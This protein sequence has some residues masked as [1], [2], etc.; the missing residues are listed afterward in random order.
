[1]R[2]MELT[3]D[4]FG[5]MNCRLCNDVVSVGAI[6]SKCYE[7]PRSVYLKGLEQHRSWPIW[8]HCLCSHMEG[9]RRLAKTL[10]QDNGCC[11]RQSNRACSEC[12]FWGL[13][14]LPACS[15]W[16]FRRVHL[17]ISGLQGKPG[18]WEHGTVSPI[19][20][21]F[22][23]LNQPPDFHKT[24]YKYCVIGGQSIITKWRPRC[25][26]VRHR[27]HADILYMQYNL[28]SNSFNHDDGPK[29]CGFIR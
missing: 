12:K 18:L 6:G 4:S 5:G 11:G 3:R 13:P 26:S 28:Q 1:M 10:N 29:L 23:L 22:K 19:C 17:V 2:L 16:Q 24:W 21:L 14:L 27:K 7:W 9:V 25:R 8:R 15:L 20:P